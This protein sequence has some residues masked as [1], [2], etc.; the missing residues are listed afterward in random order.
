MFNSTNQQLV[1]HLAEHLSYVPEKANIAD[2]VEELG[3]Y[4]RE[5]SDGCKIKAQEELIDLLIASYV[6]YHAYYPGADPE[7][8]ILRKLTK[9]KETYN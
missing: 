2:I 3:E 9:W 1:N 6:T 8:I 4:A 7:E 5:V